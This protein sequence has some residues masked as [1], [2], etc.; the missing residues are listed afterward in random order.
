MVTALIVALIAAAAFSLLFIALL[1]WTSDEAVTWGAALEVA[2]V[3]VVVATI[4][5][6]VSYRLAY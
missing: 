5:F 1:D 6:A 4:A 2:L 3:F